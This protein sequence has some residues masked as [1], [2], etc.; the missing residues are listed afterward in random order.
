[1]RLAFIDADVVP[2]PSRRAMADDDAWGRWVPAMWQA[3]ADP[4]GQHLWARPT[5][6]LMD[7]VGRWAPS[8]HLLAYSFAWPRIDLGLRR[9]IDAGR[10]ELDSRFTILNAMV[11][12][13][14]AELGEWFA[15][16]PVAEG[17]MR[18]VAAE[19]KTKLDM[20]GWQQREVP[21]GWAGRPSPVG[22]GGDPLHLAGH[23]I[24]GVFTEEDRLDEPL[25]LRNPTAGRACLIV[26]S[27]AGWYRALA[28]ATKVLT[29]RPVGHSWQVEVICRPVGHLGVFRRSRVSGRW[30]SG[31]HRVHELGILLPTPAAEAN[32][33]S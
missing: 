32:V 17:F 31:R 33:D 1:M 8:M 13:R 22:G 19:T 28:L 10:P 23:T 15:T 4:D 21:D 25:L 27:Y 29:P 11:G 2:G 18:Q 9:W 5:G 14:I 12:E 24:C 30:F 6:R 7:E 16:S 3:L 26:D 20:T